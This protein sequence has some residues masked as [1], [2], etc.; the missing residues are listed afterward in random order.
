MVEADQRKGFTWGWEKV[1]ADEPVD[2]V[3]RPAGYQ[4]VLVEQAGRDREDV[5]VGPKHGDFNQ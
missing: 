3:L 2:P 5:G 4:L 1:G